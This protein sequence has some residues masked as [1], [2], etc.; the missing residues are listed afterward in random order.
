MADSDDDMGDLIVE[1]EVDDED[2]LDSEPEE[3]AE[4]VGPAPEVL[5]SDDDDDGPAG[6][7]HRVCGKKG[8]VLRRGKE[9][10]SDQTGVVAPET[11]VRVLETRTLL[12][13]EKQEGTVRCRLGAPHAG[14]VSAKVLVNLEGPVPPSEQRALV[15]LAATALVLREEDLGAGVRIRG[16]EVGGL[17]CKIVAVSKQPIRALVLCH[18]AASNSN[19][20]LKVAWSLIVEHGLGSD[21]AV[22]LPDAPYVGGDVD[23]QTLRSW[24]P[25]PPPPKAGEAGEFEKIKASL[26]QQIYF[27]EDMIIKRGLTKEQE[28]HHP[29]EVETARD[30]LV[31]MFQGVSD[32][33]QLPPDKVWF[34]GFDQGATL[35]F[36]ALKSLGPEV[37][38]TPG[39]CVLLSP[40]S[41]FLP[42]HKLREKARQV[43]VLLAHGDE[44]A[45]VP[46][47]V[48]QCCR[49]TVKR[50]G[51][52][53]VD[54]RKCRGGHEITYQALKCVAA[55]MG[56]RLIDPEECDDTVRREATLLKAEKNH[57][58]TFKE[59]QT[60]QKEQAAIAAAEAAAPKKK[61]KKKKKKAV[62]IPVSEPPPPEP[63]APDEAG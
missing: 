37:R 56:G 32:M 39:G 36:E 7:L 53:R 13:A 16:G 9:L 8:A 17:A 30:A 23:G 52:H 27:G 1:D 42:K 44:D 51:C 47:I 61:K 45:M 38:G 2:L 11:E 54:L 5:Y 35:A 63:P 26:T 58:L 59:W 10:D 14:W 41:L 3:E 22:F 18:G 43:P 48:A 46:F 31:D 33:T 12:S 62:A 50:A 24:W 6:V 20:L 28:P 15:R 60:Y 29:P 49:V 57:N 19:E 55:L 40:A 21:T 4:Q 25:P 34:G